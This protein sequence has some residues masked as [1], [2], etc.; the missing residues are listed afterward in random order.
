MT[1]PSA[2]DPSL[3]AP[4][5]VGVVVPTLN[6]PL[7]LR[8]TL[9]SVREQDYPGVLKTIVVYDQSEP[10]LSLASDDPLRPVEV[11]VN[12]R[13]PGAAGARNSGLLAAGTEYVGF[14]DDTDLFLPGKVTAQ[15]AVLTS[16]PETEVVCCGLR[17]FGR[18][19]EDTDRGI[20]RPRVTREDLLGGHNPNLHPSALLLR[21]SSGL[22][23]DEEIPGSY[24]EDYEFV[25]RAAGRA[26]IRQIPFVGL[27]LRW[28]EGSYFSV[29]NNAPLISEAAQW[30]LAKHE[31]PCGGYAHWAGKVAFAE[32]VSA[33]RSSALKWIWRTMVARPLDPRALLALA[34]TVGVPAAFIMKN[35]DRIGR[36]V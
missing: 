33:R 19:I 16:E 35:L 6:R 20:P 25:L 14:C 30:M 21:R 24:G 31:F 1:P 22:L 34:V 23:F 26:P 8:E 10:D 18:T 5:S 15:V 28:H 9:E 17:L 32:A 3:T 13:T 11:I 36:G 4:P 12:T 29:L 7:L 2:T 27:G